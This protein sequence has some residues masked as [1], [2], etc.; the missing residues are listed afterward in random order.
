MDLTVD[1]K[2]SS[3][4]EGAV[5]TAHKSG[6]T[7]APGVEG[8]CSE[9]DGCGRSMVTG[10]LVPSLPFRWSDQNQ[11]VDLVSQLSGKL[12][13]AILQVSRGG[14]AVGIHNH[15]FDDMNQRHHPSFL[16]LLYFTSI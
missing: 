4:A 8:R 3:V 7:S 12:Q 10:G 13:E 5:T 14:Q 16:S 2:E 1:G 11:F 15:L 6:D 9:L